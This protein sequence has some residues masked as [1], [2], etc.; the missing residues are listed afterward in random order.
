MAYRLTQKETSFQTN[1]I[2]EKDG[3]YS[4]WKDKIL[5]VDTKH[6]IVIF[7]NKLE[8][9]VNHSYPKLK[10]QNKNSRDE[11]RTQESGLEK[12]KSTNLVD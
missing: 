10:R 7:V 6:S 1:K 2:R 5:A 9:R 8:C 12:L 11:F 4:L 3:K